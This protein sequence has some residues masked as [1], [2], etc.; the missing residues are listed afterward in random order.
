MGEFISRLQDD[1]VKTQISE[2]QGRVNFTITGYL[3]NNSEPS[4]AFL[5]SRNLSFPSIECKSIFLT[6]HSRKAKSCQR[7]LI[8]IYIAEIGLAHLHINT[9]HAHTC[10]TH[11]AVYSTTE[12]YLAAEGSL[13]C[14]LLISQIFIFE[15]PKIFFF[16][17]SSNQCQ[18]KLVK[19]Y[20]SQ[21]LIVSIEL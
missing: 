19:S 11:T 20:I 15:C 14:E 17:H 13:S 8:C 21:Q 6:P 12:D 2:F 7:N 1:S 18:Q 5:F 3:P 10:I 9:L 4:Q 16:S